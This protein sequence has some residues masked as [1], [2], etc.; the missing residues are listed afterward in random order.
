MHWC[1]RAVL[2]P[3]NNLSL[4]TKACLVI[5]KG[6]SLQVK[7]HLV[8]SSL[9]LFLWNSFEKQYREKI[10]GKN[11]QLSFIITLTEPLQT[12]VCRGHRLPILT[13]FLV[14]LTKLHLTFCCSSSV[15]SFN[16]SCAF[17]SWFSFSE[18]LAFSSTIVSWYCP[19][20]LWAHLNSS[21]ISE[22]FGHN[23]VKV[24]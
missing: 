19:R 4:S 10:E 17:K 6:C 20:E 11:F 21:C 8:I 22:F 12:E 24:H 18:I 7:F 16:A 1:Q 3:S 9:P 14:Y 5:S 23:T 15:V 13:E 2:I